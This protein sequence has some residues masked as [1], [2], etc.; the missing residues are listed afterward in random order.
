MS[1]V[2]SIE[3]R[4]EYEDKLYAIIYKYQIKY[5]YYIFENQ[6]DDDKQINKL[7]SLYRHFQK[8]LLKI[9]DWSSDKLHKE[10][11]KFLEWCKRKYDLQEEELQKILDT[12]ITLFVKIM[13][14][15]KTIIV[16]GILESYTFPKLKYFFYKCLKRISR[17]YYENPKNLSIDEN[18]DILNTTYKKTILDLIGSV[19][20]NMLP[21][22]QIMSILEYKDLINEDK[23]E[24]ENIFIQYDFNNTKTSESSHNSN[25][26]VIIEKQLSECSLKYISS[27][28]FDKEYCKSESEQEIQQHNEEEDLVKHVRIPKIKRNKQQYLNRQ[29]RNDLEEYFFDE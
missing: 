22:K 1:L 10:Y 23:S 21:M 15:K 24:N 16:E 3:V 11:K 25:P 14:N 28:D 7:N 18:N 20:Y 4:K 27:D 9:A 29:N 26:K 12:I 13:I 6:Y 2:K 8:R 19:V 17:H 5:I